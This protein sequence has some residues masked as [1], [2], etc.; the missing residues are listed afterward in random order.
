MLCELCETRRTVQ[1]ARVSVVW[2]MCV[3]ECGV[4][5]CVV[6]WMAC[7]LMWCGYWGGEGGQGEGVY[8]N[9]ILATREQLRG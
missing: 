8:Q 5:I 3:C 2:V 4:G 9:D 6:W 1:C 7:G